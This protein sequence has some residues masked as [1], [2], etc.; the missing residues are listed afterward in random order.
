VLNKHT[1]KPYNDTD[2]TQKLGGS[3]ALRSKH[4]ECNKFLRNMQK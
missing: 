2:L 3:T 1:H 4:D